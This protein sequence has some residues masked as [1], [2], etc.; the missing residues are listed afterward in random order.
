[1]NGTPIA[2]TLSAEAYASRADDIARIT[3]DALRSREPLAGGAR[4]TFTASGDTER[5]LRAVIAAEAD[6]CAFL[7]FDLE[8]EAD[9]LRLDITGPEAAQPIIAELFA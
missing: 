6:C 1:M 4:L 8:R 3:R 5:D 7:R 9:V 2:C